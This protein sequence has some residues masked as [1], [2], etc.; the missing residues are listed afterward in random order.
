MSDDHN[1][2][3]AGYNS[4]SSFWSWPTGSAAQTGVVWR[5][6]DEAAK[7]RAAA[8]QQSYYSGSTGFSSGSSTPSSYG[9]SSY[10]SASS[11]SGYSSSPSYASPG[12]GAFGASSGASAGD[13]TGVLWLGALIAICLGLYWV[14]A[15]FPNEVAL[16]AAGVALTFVAA[17]TDWI[18]DW[19]VA[20][21]FASVAVA[22]ATIGM[23]FAIHA[24]PAFPEGVFTKL[25]LAHP[26]AL[27]D[28]VAVAGVV[29][30]P[31]S[32]ATWLR[33]NGLKFALCSLAL[34]LALGA[35]YGVY[36]NLV[37]KQSAPLATAAEV[38]DRSSDAGSVVFAWATADLN[39]HPLAVKILSL[40][41]RALYLPYGAAAWIGGAAGNWGATA[42]AVVGRKVVIPAFEYAAR[43]L[44]KRLPPD[45]PPH[46]AG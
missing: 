29:A 8:D 1:S 30:Y 42:A 34:A 33:N 32:I 38:F 36:D 7:A 44:A 5:E 27:V 31:A 43:E 17:T 41:A 15:R 10:G 19:K 26:G 45:D 25:V 37:H 6:Q 22:I 28:A 39:S 2:I 11:S 18:R 40:P 13:A 21:I 23:G 16:G 24:N 20:R 12:Y 3:G 14:W 35:T 46:K 9:S 4:T